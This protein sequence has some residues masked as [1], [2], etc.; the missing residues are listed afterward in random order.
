[1]TDALLEVKDLSVRFGGFVALQDVSWAVR[2]ADVVADA[3]ELV[4]L[5]DALA[6]SGLFFPARSRPRGQEPAAQKL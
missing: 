1:M 5:V 3:G 6:Q 4:G 2:P